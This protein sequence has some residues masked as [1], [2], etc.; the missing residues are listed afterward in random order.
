MRYNPRIHRRR[1]IRL[2]S[3]DY[4]DSAAYFVTICTY[5][6]E[7]LFEND[8]FRAIV[9]QVWRHI[10]TRSRHLKGDEFI[11][12]PNHVHAILWIRGI[13]H[14]RARTVPDERG[15]PKG[16][17]LSTAVGSFKSAVARRI[18]ETRRTAGAPV[19]QRGLYDR[20]IRDERE[21]NMIRAYI[22]DN[23]RKWAEDRYHPANDPVI[24]S[25][26]GA[27]YTAQRL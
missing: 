13:E 18:N 8:A 5:Q 7:L 24:A 15:T 11:V 26:V 21:L 1:S 23:P 16:G 12:M 27:R 6:R 20:V 19:W 9:E 14:S 4:R 25:T 17:S 22:R 3:W 2:Q 10:T